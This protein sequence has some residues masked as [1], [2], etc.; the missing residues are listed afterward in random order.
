MPQPPTAADAAGGEAHVEISGPSR[1]E[2]RLRISSAND[3]S[4]LI[5][6]EDDIAE[7]HE[8]GEGYEHIEELL[9][10]LHLKR[11]DKLER[12]AEICRRLLMR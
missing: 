6:A 1:E 9:K 5:S 10:L 7:L 8:A 12:E 4:A 3:D 2:I 11:K